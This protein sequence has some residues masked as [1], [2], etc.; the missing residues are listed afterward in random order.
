MNLLQGLST[1]KLGVVAVVLGLLLTLPAVWIGFAQDDH[2]FL[3]VFKGSP[4]FDTQELGPLETFSFSKGDPADRHELMERGLLPWWTVEGWK[5]NF[6]RPISSLSSWVDYRLFGANAWAMHLHS[7]ALYGILIA[8]ATV[9]YRRLIEPRWAA[10]LAAIA[11]A[12]DS[13]HAIPVTWLAM[14]NAIL[15][16][17]FGLLLLAAHDRW[18]KAR[19]GGRPGWFFGALSTLWLA[20]ALLSGESGVSVGGYLLAYALFLDPTHQGPERGPAGYVRAIAALLPYLAVVILW[21]IAYSSLGYGTEGSGLYIDPVADPAEF[22][23][24]LP[25]RLAV[26]L[27]GLLAMPD[28]MLW[29]LTPAP[30]SHV[31][32]ALSIGFLF[33]FGW[34]VLPLLRRSPEARFMFVGSVLA[35]VPGCA[36]LPMDR[37]MMFSSFGALGLSAMLLADLSACR[38]GGF[39]G[40]IR[41]PLAIFLIVSH[42]VV[43]PLGLIAGTQHIRIMNRVLNGSNPSIPVDL[44]AS[45]RVVAI[46]T[47]NDLLGASLP[48]HRSSRGEPLVQHWWW[49]YSGMEDLTVEREDARTIILR[50]EGGY[51]TTPWA[52]IFRLPATDPIEAGDR[53]SLDGLEI[54]VIAATREGV[55]SEVRFRFDTPLEDPSLR[56]VSWRD[57]AY[58]PFFPP[59]PGAS[60][61]VP[62]GRLRQLIDLALG[63]K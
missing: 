32:L 41:S 17:L 3:M 13:G 12:V 46:N 28:A 20:L 36:T 26:L 18:R 15:T 35:A 11:F 33:V 5:L 51:F 40:R 47:P 8:I 24:R 21:R 56:F 44:P 19:A 55:P 16:L 45:T 61:A 6:W 59:A 58:V 30:W 14:R 53:F 22:L 38:A 48:I 1:R 52:D 9:L 63:W 27:L 7:L 34:A 57:G 62:G 60:V 25:V 49:L 50:P 31:Q 10:G 4:G 39:R 43:A 42:F 23:W 37:L 54:E 29:S 2:F